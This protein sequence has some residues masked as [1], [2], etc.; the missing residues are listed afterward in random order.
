[1]A[2]VNSSTVFYR[3]LQKLNQFL[4][5]DFVHISLYFIFRQSQHKSSLHPAFFQPLS[6]GGYISSRRLSVSVFYILCIFQ[7]VYH[8]NVV[9]SPCF[10]ISP[11]VQLLRNSPVSTG[12]FCMVFLKSLA[13][14]SFVT[15]L[16][17]ASKSVFCTL[18]NLSRNA[19]S[20]ETSTLPQTDIMLA[21]FLF[22]KQFPDE[23]LI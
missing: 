1:M 23:C 10:R 20:S 6:Y 19:V 22:L 13:A 7:R 9:E 14:M 2:F 12:V 15:A 4:F 3:L 21:S 18:S 8:F 16:Q 17:K 11:T 5:Y